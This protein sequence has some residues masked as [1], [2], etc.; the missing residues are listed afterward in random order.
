MRGWNY[1]AGG[2]A[3]TLLWMHCEKSAYHQQL[4]EQLATGQ[5]FDTILFDIHF[6]MQRN[7]FF[8]YCWKKN[9]EGL[10]TNGSTNTTVRYKTKEF[11]SK[12]VYVDF[13]PTFYNDRI[14]EMP[15]YF[16][17]EAFAPWDKSFSSDSLYAEVLTFITTKYETT[18]ADIK[19]P[20]EPEPV[21]ISL[22]GNRRIMLRKEN[23][24][25]VALFSDMSL[26]PDRIL[27]KKEK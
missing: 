23:D 7:D 22:R 3:L 17:Y 11:L 1:W 19:L 10:F 26:H 24:K 18:F 20:H 9:Q 27:K 25:V 8:A 16:N 21:K 14:I 13:Y 2:L 6:G 4:S 5:R 15:V 12:P